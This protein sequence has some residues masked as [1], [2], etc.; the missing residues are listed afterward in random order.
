MTDL[1]TIARLNRPPPASFV[2]VVAAFTIVAGG[3]PL[4]ELAAGLL[5]SGAR[6]SY[7]AVL[8]AV[9]RPPALPLVGLQPLP[10]NSSSASC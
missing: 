9:V 4:A 8:V 2:E 3:R 1:T 6:F 7:V 5:G 10:F